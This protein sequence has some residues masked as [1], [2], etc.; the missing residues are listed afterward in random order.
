MNAPARPLNPN[1]AL[2]DVETQRAL[3]GLLVEKLGGTVTI[4]AADVK[5]SPTMKGSCALYVETN[6][7]EVTLSVIPR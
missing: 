3:I 7:A 4:T 6:G 5:A 2:W 1:T